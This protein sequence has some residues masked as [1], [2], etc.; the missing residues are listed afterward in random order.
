MLTSADCACVRSCAARRSAL[1]LALLALKDGLY[2]SGRVI[3]EF[4][5]E[6]DC[7]AVAIHSRLQRDELRRSDSP[8]AGA[9]GALHE[10]LALG[11]FL[12]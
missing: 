10:T 12:A 2:S 8:V 4:G 9:Q 3:D 6:I 1:E 7:F 11:H 5:G